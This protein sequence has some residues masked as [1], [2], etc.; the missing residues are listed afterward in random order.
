MH[1]MKSFGITAASVVVTLLVIKYV[2]PQEWRA[3][4]G[5]M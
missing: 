1:H 3:K 5:L 2:V 4:L